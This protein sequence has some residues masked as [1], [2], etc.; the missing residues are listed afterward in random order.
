MH[1]FILSFL[2]LLSSFQL[3]A[4]DNYYRNFWRPQ[5]HGLPLNYCDVNMKDC[6]A[7]IANRYCQLMGYH[8]ANQYI[9]EHNTGLTNFISKKALCR[10][11]TCNAFKTIRC[12]AHL[13][14]KPNAAYYYRQRHF[15]LPRFDPNYRLDWCYDGHKNCGQRAAQS[16]CRQMGYLK[17]TKF[18][19]QSYIHATKAIANQK[20]CF[21]AKCKAFAY[22]DCKR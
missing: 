5:F 12:V 10:G 17:A 11:W 9:M 4:E 21:G 6:G 13:E 22:I 15:V 1:L 16:F 20:L 19:E 14:H 3:H 7:P 18:K 8:H 2:L